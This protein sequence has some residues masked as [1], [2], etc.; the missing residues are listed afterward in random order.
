MMRFIFLLL[1]ITT[2]YADKHEFH[3][4]HHLNKELSHLDLS[5][6][7]NIQVKIILKEFRGELKKFKE[8]EEEIEDK[9]KDLFTAESLDT[10]ALDVLNQTLDEKSHTIEKE[11]LKK[12]H[13]VLTQEQRKR[14]IYYFDDWKVQ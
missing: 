9:R 13:A 3:S 8:L 6:E 14:F 2:L 10:D 11:F 1:L 12:I 5:Q 4:E 7:Q